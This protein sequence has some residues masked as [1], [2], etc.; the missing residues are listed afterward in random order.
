MLSALSLKTL[1]RQCHPLELSQC[2]NTYENTQQLMM[3]T[4][5]HRY[6]SIDHFILVL[7][8]KNKICSCPFALKKY[9]F[10]IES[11][12]QKIPDG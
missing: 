3:G 11:D 7:V 2:L 9:S 1:D 8:K 12:F 4:L 5:I 10:G 6:C